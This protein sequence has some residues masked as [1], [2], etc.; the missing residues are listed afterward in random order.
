MPVRGDFLVELR[1]FEPMAIADVGSDKVVNFMGVPAPIY[2]RSS[3]QTREGGS[4]KA[5]PRH[6]SR[7]SVPANHS[8]GTY[9]SRTLNLIP[10]KG[11]EIA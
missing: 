8:T 11:G 2:Y 9:S 10:S 6:K 3:L 1:G 5:R 4:S 7:L